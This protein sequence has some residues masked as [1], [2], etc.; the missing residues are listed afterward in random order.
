MDL[1]KAQ[2]INL[3]THLCNGD[4]YRALAWS[5]TAYDGTYPP[6][7]RD[8]ATVLRAQGFLEA[9]VPDPLVLRAWSEGAMPLPETSNYDQ[10]RAMDATGLNIPADPL[11]A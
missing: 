4:A 7:G 3:A 6:L 11:L 10:A 1:S 9:G 2:S 5:H 8:H